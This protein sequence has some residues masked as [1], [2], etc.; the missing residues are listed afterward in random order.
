MG[1]LGGKDWISPNAFNS[2]LGHLGHKTECSP[3]WWHSSTGPALSVSHR[4]PARDSVPP[5]TNA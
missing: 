1:G 4:E 3:G 2:G 5:H